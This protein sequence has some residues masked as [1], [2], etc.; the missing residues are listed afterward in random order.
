MPYQGKAISI[1]GSEF[2]VPEVVKIFEHI[3]C[4]G[5]SLKLL[6]SKSKNY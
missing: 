2:K 4:S 1:G 3:G 5:P 6:R